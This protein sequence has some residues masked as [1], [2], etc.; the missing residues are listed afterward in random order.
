MTLTHEGHLNLLE[1]LA[2]SKHFDPNIVELIMANK[3][4]LQKH[5]MILLDRDKE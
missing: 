3:Y 2:D 4:R 1:T 5:M